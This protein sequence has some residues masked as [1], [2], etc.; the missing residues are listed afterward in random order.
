MS[1]GSQRANVLRRNLALGGGSGGRG[2]G[3]G[4]GSGSGGGEAGTDAMSE[5]QRR[6]LRRRAEALREAEQG[7]WGKSTVFVGAAAYGVC[8]SCN[9][10]VAKCISVRVEV[11]EL[12]ASRVEPV[13]RRLGTQR[14]ASVGALAVFGSAGDWR[15]VAAAAATRV[16][17]LS[18]EQLKKAVAEEDKYQS[19]KNWSSTKGRGNRKAPVARR[20]DADALRKFGVYPLQQYPP[21]AV[22]ATCS[23]QVNAHFLRE[24]QEISCA[25]P[26]PRGAGARGGIKSAAAAGVK[27]GASE[28]LS[29]D[30][31][32]AG[33]GRAAKATRREVVR[34]EREREREQRREQ[35]RAEKERKKREKD[36]KRE[37]ELAVARQPLDLD[38]Q[39]GVAGDGG[40]APCSRSLTCKTHSMAMK[41]AVRGRSKLF[42][43][44]LQAHLAKSRSAAAAK[45]AAAGHGAAA[46]SSAAAAAVRSAA[47]LALGATADGLDESFFGDDSD[48]GSDDEAERVIAAVRCSRPAPLAV[49][50]TVLPRRRHRYLR[51]RDL[52]YD[53][54][55]P[56]MGAEPADALAS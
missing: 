41:R 54:L 13:A 30:G 16:V 34:A 29:E 27:R 46:R 39:C 35:L 32:G 14:L 9:F 48:R 19:K 42:D 5:E 2:S 15:A 49:R 51:V 38:R 31:D 22:C 11:E 28:A 56:S 17:G 4:S 12:R 40:A 52:F 50:S 3:S 10:G 55:K 45:S 33:A 24:H 37:R 26:P 23:R 8:G 21:V 1:S 47:A 53:A 43:A 44:L 7:E 36:E 25:V 18:W 6:I 20:L